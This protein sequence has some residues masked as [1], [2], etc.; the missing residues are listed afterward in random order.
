MHCLRSASIMRFRS[1]IPGVAREVG[2]PGSGGVP[3]RFSS[4]GSACEKNTT[5]QAFQAGWRFASNARFRLRFGSSV[6]AL[7]PDAPNR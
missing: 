4:F 1:S 6:Q 3:G 5:Y 7:T 2:W